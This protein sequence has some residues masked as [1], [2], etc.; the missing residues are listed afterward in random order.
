MLEQLEALVDKYIYIIGPIIG[1]TPKEIL[2]FKNQFD[3]FVVDVEAV[4]HGLVPVVGGLEVVVTDVLELLKIL[5]LDWT[6]PSEWCRYC[7]EA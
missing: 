3:Q 5:H 7:L 2:Q 6:A 4:E 1:L